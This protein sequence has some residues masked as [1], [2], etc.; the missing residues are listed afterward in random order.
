MVGVD[1]GEVYAPCITNISMDRSNLAAAGSVLGCYCSLPLFAPVP[2]FALSPRDEEDP[3]CSC[4]NKFRILG[5]T[6]NLCTD[7]VDIFLLGFS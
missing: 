4:A 1:T 3:A 7:L 6:D 2:S 5:D